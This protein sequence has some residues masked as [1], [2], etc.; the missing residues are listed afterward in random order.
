MRLYRPSYLHPS[1]HTLEVGTCMTGRW[2][3]HPSD[4][5]TRGL[6]LSR[7]SHPI[8]PLWKDG[9]QF[10]DTQGRTLRAQSVWFAVCAQ[11]GWVRLE[12]LGCSEPALSG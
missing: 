2:L 3:L 7:P 4:R 8:L 6:F 12:R 11:T 9:E 5:G 1:H 10:T